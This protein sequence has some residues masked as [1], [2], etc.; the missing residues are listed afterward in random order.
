MGLTALFKKLLALIAFVSG[1]N[2]NMAVAL[3][4]V[5]SRLSDRRVRELL[6]RF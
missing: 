4:Q 1:G 5:Y 6:N 3:V 2:W